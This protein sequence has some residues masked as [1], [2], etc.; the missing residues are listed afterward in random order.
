MKT[1]LIGT[2]NRHKVKEIAQFLQDLP[3]TIKS[4]LDFPQIPPVQEMGSTLKENAILKAKT[5][6]KATG[7]LTLADDTGLEVDA[8]HGAPGVYSARYAGENCTYFDN[9][10]KLLRALE[11]LTSEQRTAKFKCVVACYEPASDHLQIAEGVLEGEILT[12][13]QGQNG[14]GYDP[15]FFVPHLKKTLA[16]LDLFEKNKISHRA[17]ALK[18]AKQILYAYD[19][20]C[21]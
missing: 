18:K 20:H 12:K 17:L 14:F 11:G 13:M 4:L 6:A 9:N 16:E 3:W 15:V 8:L 19:T 21:Q 10:Q 5:Y 1:L 7:L 2:H